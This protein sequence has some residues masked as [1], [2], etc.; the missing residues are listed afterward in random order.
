MA[1]VDDEGRTPLSYATPEQL[2]GVRIK[3]KL[4]PFG[5]APL[6]ALLFLVVLASLSLFVVSEFVRWWN[7]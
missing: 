6:L 4:K 7:S 3:I 5:W 1:N 2:A